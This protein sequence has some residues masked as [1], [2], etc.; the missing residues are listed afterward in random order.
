MTKEEKEKDFEEL[1]N[2]IK[3]DLEIIER[4]KKENRQL[5]E[6]NSKLREII[7]E[8]VKMVNEELAQGYDYSKVLDDAEKIKTVDED[9]IDEQIDILTDILER[10]CK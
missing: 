8:L 10:W 7:S 5:R 4:I 3:K 2:I 1:M 9:E 6:L